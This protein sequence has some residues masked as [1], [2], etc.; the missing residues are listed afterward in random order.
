MKSE[1]PSK[2]HCWKTRIDHWRSSGKSARQWCQEHN[3][4][5]SSLGYWKDKLSEQQISKDSFIEI[6]AEA[7]A[8]IT[9]KYKDLEVCL[10]KAFDEQ[11]LCRCLQTIRR[12]LC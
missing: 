6:P 5:P 1:Q 3:I 7:A 9:I 11:T 2:Q 12:V 8:G 10:D 4:S